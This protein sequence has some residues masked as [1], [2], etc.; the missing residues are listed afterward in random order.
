MNTRPVKKV[1]I[2]LLVLA[3]L[4]FAL[5]YFYATASTATRKIDP[6]PTANLANVDAGLIEAGRYVAT[7]ADCIACHTAPGGKTYAGGRVI[8]SPVGNIYSS[9]ITPDKATGIGN[10]TLDDFDRAVRHGIDPDGGTLYPAMP[11]PSY[12]RMSDNDLRALYAYFMRAVAP[13]SANNRGTD[14]SWP[15]SMRWPLGIWR[16]TFAPIQAPMDVT[17][18]A[19]QKIG[20]GAYLVQSLGHCGSCHTPRAATLQELAMDESGPEFLSGGPQIDG[21]LAVNL[22][23]DQASGLGNWS[24]QDIVATFRTARN[25]H[26]AVLGEPMQDVVVHSTSQMR[27]A[28][29]E[30]MALYLKSLSLTG[31]GRTSFAA[32]NATVQQVMSGNDSE[33]GMQLYLDNCSACHRVD[34]KASRIVFPGLP[35][36]PTVLQDNPASLIRVILAGARLPSLEKAPSDLGMPGFAWRLSD[37]ETAHLATFVRNAWGNKAPPVGA[38]DVGE[39]R[40]LLKQGDIHEADQTNAQR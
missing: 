15:L 27:D 34:G 18:Y 3:L 25:S 14:I 5:A 37:E 24:V 11:Y 28:D 4:L 10:Y 23:A 2:A 35:G 8:Q 22:R 38:A 6:G 9:N 16:K 26:T 39:V 36:N 20:R 7:A 12:G 19:D 1:L 33:R 17:R 32:S 29:L 40:K 13:V 21:W 31:T 30:A